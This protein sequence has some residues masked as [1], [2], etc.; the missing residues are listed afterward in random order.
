M[1]SPR[2]TR[3]TRLF[4]GLA[5]ASMVLLPVLILV[6]LIAPGQTGIDIQGTSQLSDGSWPANVWAGLLVGFV[7]LVFSMLALNGMRRLFALYRL[8]DP[9]SPQA[10]PLI[11]S[12]GKNVLIASILG[13]VLFPAV[14]GLLSLSNPVGERSISVA[15]SINDIGFILVAGLLLMIGWSMTEATK[16]VAENKE[17]I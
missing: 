11:K 2:L 14:S 3:A 9:L 8:G 12:I 7:P 16:V 10:G 4:H 15:I 13:V 1:L 6:G 5:I 17:F